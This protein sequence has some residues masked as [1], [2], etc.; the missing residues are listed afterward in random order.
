M[1]HHVSYWELRAAL[2]EW[3]K[4]KQISKKE[5]YFYS[6]GPLGRERHLDFVFLNINLSQNEFQYLTGGYCGI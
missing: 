3:Q 4:V 1:N 2:T 6:Q 5:V